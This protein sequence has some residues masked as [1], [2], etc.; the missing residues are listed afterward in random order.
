MDRWRNG[1]KSEGSKS[2]PKGR[3]RDTLRSRRLVNEF[4]DKMSYKEDGEENYLAGKNINWEEGNVV[5]NKGDG[6][7]REGG[8]EEVYRGTNHGDSLGANT[9]GS[10]LEESSYSG[11]PYG[12]NFQPH[13]SQSWTTPCVTGPAYMQW[14]CFPVLLSAW[15]SWGT[16]AWGYHPGFVSA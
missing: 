15:S 12:S 14:F 16:G 6:T 9:Q 8:S 3:R 10:G 1:L 5:G 7:S 2:T 4:Q 11:G 13:S